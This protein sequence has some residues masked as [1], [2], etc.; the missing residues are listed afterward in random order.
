MSII[1]G[2]SSLN[3]FYEMEMIVTDDQAQDLVLGLDTFLFSISRILEQFKSKFNCFK[4]YLICNAVLQVDSISLN[5]QQE[6][7]PLDKFQ[8][9]KL[10]QDL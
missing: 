5:W 1:G 10:L 6:P 9:N 3:T 7:C 4:F 8:I 2:K